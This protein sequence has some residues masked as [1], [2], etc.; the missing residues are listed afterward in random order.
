MT[1]QGKVKTPDPD[2]GNNDD[3]IGILIFDL[4]RASRSKSCDAAAIH[5]SAIGNL[6]IAKRND[7]KAARQKPVDRQAIV[8]SGASV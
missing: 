7:T 8:E 2:A 4:Q 6:A 5:G 1:E 3:D